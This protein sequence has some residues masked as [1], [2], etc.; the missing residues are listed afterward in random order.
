MMFA[1]TSADQPIDLAASFESQTVF[2]A[3]SNIVWSSLSNVSIAG[4]V[5]TPEGRPIKGAAIILKDA[6]TNAV[7]RSSMS[8]AFGYY[9]LDQIETG[10]LYVLSVSHKNYI[11]AFP[12]HLLEINE[13]RTG[14]D[15]TGEVNE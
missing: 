7:I 9:R 15:F 1:G 2:D 10:R 8:S 3:D 11:F 14:V 4:R 6:D 13:D 5:K 12:A